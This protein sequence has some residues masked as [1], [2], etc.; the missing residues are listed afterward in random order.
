VQP[1]A[2]PAIGNA[3]LDHP[4]RSLAIVVV[5]ALGVISPE[6][7]AADC[8]LNFLSRH[9]RLFPRAIRAVSS[10]P[11]RECRGAA[12]WAGEG[13]YHPC[14]WSRAYRAAAR[15]PAAPFVR[16]GP[17]RTGRPPRGPASRVW[18]VWD[19]PHACRRAF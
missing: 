8:P 14:R 7:P 2:F 19:K 17:E 18:R 10:T 12:S 1:D 13:K 4:A 11:I 3:E 16:D 15:P 6:N 9:P 5:K